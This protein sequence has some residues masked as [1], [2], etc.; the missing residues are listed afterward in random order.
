MN[1]ARYKKGKLIALADEWKFQEGVT[2][3]TYLMGQRLYDP[4]S[5]RL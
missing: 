5:L 3:S 2:M 1:C 4:R